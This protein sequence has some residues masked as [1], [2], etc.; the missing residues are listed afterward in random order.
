LTKQEI[1]IELAR[2]RTP[3]L[4]DAIEKFDVRPRTEGIMD[5][6]IRSLLPSLG[7]MIGYACTGKVVGADPPIEGEPVVAWRNV[8]ELAQKSPSPT[9]MVAQ[10][11]DNPPARSCA[12]GDVA[13]SVMLQLGVVGAVTNGGVRD[14]SEVEQLGFQL[15]APA[16]VVGHAHT[17]WVEI[18][19]PVQVGSLVVHPGDLIHGDEH[20]VM[21]IPQEIPL[22]DLLVFVHKFLAS[23]KTIVDYCQGPDFDIDTLCQVI[24]EHNRRTSRH[25]S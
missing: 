1:L 20:G 9:V 2:I 10:D 11:L 21:T 23:E 12:W 17:R 7:P 25:M 5:P 24:E 18:N 16:A 15:F 3:I 4:Y 13:A 22:E 6:S 8:W 14:L 19:E